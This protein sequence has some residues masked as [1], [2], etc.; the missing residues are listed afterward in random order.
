MY[1]YIT[2]RIRNYVVHTVEIN[3][4]ES[5]RMFGKNNKEDTNGFKIRNGKLEKYRGEGGEVIIPDYITSIEGYAFLDCKKL[6]GITI[7]NSVESIGGNAFWGCENLTR[8]TIYGGVTSIGN[9]AFWECAMLKDITLPNS[10]ESIGSFAFN[11]CG[12]LSG[13]KIPSS[14]TRIGKYAFQGC[15]MLTIYAAAENEPEGWHDN[16]NPNRRPVVWKFQ[17]N[18]P[19]GSNHEKT[20]I[21]SPEERS[22]LRD[23]EIGTKQNIL[24]KYKGRGGN[25]II[26]DGVTKIDSLAFKKCG[27]LTSVTIPSSVTSIGFRAFEGCGGLTE[28]TIPSSVAIID[29][30]AFSGCGA[31]KIYAVVEREPEGWHRKWN[32]EKRPVFWGYREEDRK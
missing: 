4:K 2:I 21:P 10:V 16:W 20:T 31:L 6:I 13:I 26:P 19:I 5:E 25:V 18:L 1:F 32:P 27:T 23:F 8:V 24:F 9:N 14:V 11:G 17:G 7:P 29:K 30:D 28:I 3:V 15:G 22:D 12:M